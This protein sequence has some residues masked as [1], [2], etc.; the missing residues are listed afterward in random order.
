MPSPE[1]AP[2][3]RSP[4]KAPKKPRARS[5]HFPV[6]AA[7]SLHAQFADADRLES[8]LAEGEARLQRMRA[9]FALPSAAP[10][11]SAAPA[12]RAAQGLNMLQQVAL[13]L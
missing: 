3:L 9:C 5:P 4:P 11:G 10:A 1:P 12:A 13:A 2:A 8:A 6:R 7:R